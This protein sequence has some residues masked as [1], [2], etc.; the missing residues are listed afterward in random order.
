MFE[1]VWDWITTH[2]EV[3]EKSKE[4]EN[5]RVDEERLYV[6]LS[7]NFGQTHDLSVFAG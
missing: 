3:E 5:I 4:I 7:T 1:T 2:F 6:S